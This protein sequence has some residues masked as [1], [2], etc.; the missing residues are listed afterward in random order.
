MTPDDTALSI[1][2]TDEE[3]VVTVEFGEFDPDG[4]SVSW[5]D[6]RLHVEA[7]RGADDGYEVAHETVAFG[8][9]VYADGITATWE[10]ALEVRV[11]LDHDDERFGM[12]VPV[13]SDDAADTDEETEAE[14]DDEDEVDAGEVVSQDAVSRYE[15]GEA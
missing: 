1:R 14:T 4:V 11:P 6:G 5:Q 12:E 2:R 8:R 7:E 10:D 9:K 13:E 3:Y 15:D